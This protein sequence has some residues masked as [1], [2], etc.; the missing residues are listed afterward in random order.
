MCV[1]VCVCVCVFVCVCA[2][3]CVCVCVRG[4]GRRGNWPLAIRRDKNAD[5]NEESDSNLPTHLHSCSPWLDPRGLGSDKERGES[6]TRLISAI[7]LRAQ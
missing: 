4:R 3:L 2:R 6:V 7:C 5:V 1:C